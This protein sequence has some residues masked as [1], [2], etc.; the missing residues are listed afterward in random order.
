MIIYGIINKINGKMYIGKSINDNVKSMRSRSQLHLHGKGS[1]LVFQAVQKY[2]IENFIVLI[3]HK[4]NCT[5]EKLEELEKWYILHFNTISK[6]G[7]NMTKGG[8]GGCGKR[9]EASKRKQSNTMLGKNTGPKS[10]EHVRKMIDTQKIL[11]ST[12]ERKKE[13][14]EKCIYGTHIRYHWNKGVLNVDCQHC[15]DQV[16]KEHS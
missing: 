12:P 4:E 7:Y 3:L 1:K 13:Q 9:S 8:D 14:S 15:I 10:P 5:K 11:W 6:N 16:M 2:G